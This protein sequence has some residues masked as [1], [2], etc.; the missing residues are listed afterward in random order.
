[1][2]RRVLTVVLRR[3]LWDP[4]GTATPANITTINIAAR[5]VV[6]KARDSALD[7]A[8]SSEQQQQWVFPPHITRQSRESDGMDGWLTWHARIVDWVKAGPQQ[9]F[10]LELGK[11]SATTA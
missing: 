2:T 1:M 4:T 5:S 8:L 9:A 3:L 6:S 10:R 7:S 11:R